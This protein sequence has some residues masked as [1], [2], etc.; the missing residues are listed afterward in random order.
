MEEWPAPSAGTTVISHSIVAITGLFDRYVRGIKP[1][2]EIH[3]LGSL[4]PFTQVTT[5]AAT[6]IDYEQSSVFHHRW[7]SVLCPVLGVI[8]SRQELFIRRKF[9]NQTALDPVVKAAQTLDL[10]LSLPPFP[11]S[12]RYGIVVLTNHVRHATT[13]R[14]PHRILLQRTLSLLLP[15]A[16]GLTINKPA[17]SSTTRPFPL[18]SLRFRRRG[19]RRGHGRGRPIGGGGRFPIRSSRFIFR[20]TSRVDRGWWCSA[21]FS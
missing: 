3:C 15:P 13:L 2:V 7:T 9:L 20:I 18:T 16:H 17:S 21:A 14:R 19:P 1:N 10:T 11:P 12:L 5:F 6:K 4:L 8:E